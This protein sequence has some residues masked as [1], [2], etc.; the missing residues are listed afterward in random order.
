MARGKAEDVLTTP[1]APLGLRQSHYDDNED[2][3]K[4]YTDY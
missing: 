3:D 2:R 4:Q 1:D